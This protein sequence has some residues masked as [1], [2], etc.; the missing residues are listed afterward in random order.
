MIRYF[1]LLLLI[2]L[3][4]QLPSC[5][6]RE[7]IV[8]FQTN[9]P[10]STSFNCYSPTLKADDFISIQIFGEDMNAVAP[11]NLPIEG[12]SQGG[13]NGYLNG[14]PSTLG[15]LIDENGFVKMPFL[16]E[17][18]LGG[19]TRYEAVSI[20]EQKLSEY[21]S[22]PV[23]LIQILNYK[24]TVLGDVQKPGT[25]KI[26]NER[27]TI[28]EAIGLAGDLNLTG[29][30][31]NVSVIREVEGKKIRY[32]VDLTSSD[33]FDS[34]VY[35]LTQNDVVYVE[36]NSAART[37]STIWRTSGSIFISLS[38]LIITTITL[39]TRK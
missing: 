1:T 9:F 34:P 2:L 21:L 20:L 12:I 39:I 25:Y 38:S 22:N 14:N 13:N 16:G 28:L 17:I 33:L 31:K 27:I 29:E 35:Y 8:Y 23:V 7:K 37:T 18:K 32:N 4:M 10:D 30:R 3:L 36:P 6:T 26:P 5:K 19:Y 11:F 15:Y 24:I